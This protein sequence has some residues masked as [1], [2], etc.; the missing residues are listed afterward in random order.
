MGLSVVA[1]LT[2]GGTLVYRLISGLVGCQSLPSAEAAGLLV[3]LAVFLGG[4]ALVLVCLWV[5]IGSGSSGSGTWGFPG[6]VPG[7]WL[8]G[9]GA[10]MADCSARVVPG[11]GPVGWWAGNPPVLTG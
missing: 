8:V 3:H 7:C 1:G 5:L 2:T 11:L 9:L 4:P 10:G 6:L